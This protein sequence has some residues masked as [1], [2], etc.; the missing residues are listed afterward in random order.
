MNSNITIDIQDGIARIVMDDGKVNAMS[1]GLMN[2]ISGALDAAEAADAVVVLSGREGIF[3]AGFDMRTFSQGAEASLE[4][5]RTGAELIVRLLRFPQ[6]V[7]TACTGHA[8]PMGAFLMLAAD[9]RIGIDG[10]WKIGMNEVAI[11]LTVPQFA[12]EL[13]RYRLTPP[14]FANVNVAA[15]FAPRDAVRLGYL[16]HVVKPEELESRAAE[17]AARLR[18]LDIGSF[19]GTKTRINQHAIDAITAAISS[20]YGET[21]KTIADT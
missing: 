16:D 19:V 2:E 9:A 3:S 8:Y 5:V 15:M 13:A 20:E 7:L 18:S 14:G 11:G 6:P 17:E 4:M 12:V 10:P 1:I 21:E